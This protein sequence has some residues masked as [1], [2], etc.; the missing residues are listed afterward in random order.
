MNDKVGNPIEI[1]AVIVWQVNDTAKAI[2]EVDN[3]SQYVSIQSEAAIRNLAGSYPYDHF[4][5]E[6]AE[7]TLRGGA[8]LVNHKLESE[9]HDRLERA[10]INVIEARIS[11]LSYAPEIAGAMLQRQ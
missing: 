1:A 10:G 6:I 3:I 4:D 7:I 11:H 2:F 5:D 9:L 8:D